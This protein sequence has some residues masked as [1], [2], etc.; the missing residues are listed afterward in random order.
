[1]SSSHSLET[2]SAHTFRPEDALPPVAA[3]GTGASGAPRQAAAP[4]TTNTS[5]K[6]KTA[7]LTMLKD[8][9]EEITRIIASTKEERVSAREKMENAII[10]FD[11]SD[12]IISS[13][14][15][16]LP[17]DLDAY[18][19]LVRDKRRM[20]RKHEELLKQT[21]GVSHALNYHLGNGNVPGPSILQEIMAE[22]AAN[23]RAE[24][25]A[26]AQRDD[27]Q[28]D[29]DDGGPGDAEGRQQV[30]KKTR[31]YKKAV[32]A[33][34]QDPMDSAAYAKFTARDDFF[35]LLEAR[36]REEEELERKADEAEG[37]DRLERLEELYRRSAAYAEE[38][39]E[40]MHDYAPQRIHQ[41]REVTLESLGFDLPSPADIIAQVESGYTG[42]HKNGGSSPQVH[43]ANLSTSPSHSEARRTDDNFSRQVDGTESLISAGSG[44]LAKI[45]QILSRSGQQVSPQRKQTKR[46]AGRRRRG[47]NQ[48]GRSSEDWHTTRPS[49]G[50]DDYDEEDEEEAVA[51]ESRVVIPGEGVAEEMEQ[52]VMQDELRSVAILDLPDYKEVDRESRTLETSV[53]QMVAENTEPLDLAFPT[54]EASRRSALDDPEAPYQLP[55]HKMR[56]PKDVMASKAKH[57]G[58]YWTQVAREKR[59]K[60]RNQQEGRREGEGTGAGNAASGTGKKKGRRV[61]RKG[62]AQKRTR[63]RS[64]NARGAQISGGGQVRSTHAQDSS[65][66]MPGHGRHAVSSEKHER[67]GHGEYEEYDDDAG[68]LYDLDAEFSGDANQGGDAAALEQ[69]QESDEYL[70]DDFA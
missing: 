57:R 56:R 2:T 28:P 30:S 27:A 13:E 67:R 49:N 22:E 9:M 68:D 4:T 8:L 33:L 45:H 10:L 52:R 17:N 55:G 11:R 36:R 69:Q 35:H 40:F 5:H 29:H 60:Q 18:L 62:K 53:R 26:A 38:I 44:T 58:D 63:A 51:H 59:M 14:L 15:A 43:G 41:N 34:R 65:G 23:A 31:K 47:G 32:E 48:G 54:L 61:K 21:Q 64:D 1:M 37:K 6:K 24:E 39:S 50:E 42:K 16:E 25:E 70:S 20:Q 12:G 19:R 46:R 66:E 7:S 3:S